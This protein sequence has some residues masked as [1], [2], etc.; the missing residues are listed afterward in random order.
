M[1]V[2]KNCDH[3]CHHGNGGTCHCGCLNCEHDIKDALDKLEEIE[4]LFYETKVE[5]EAD[6]DL[7]SKTH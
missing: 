2:C 7:D 5:F 6:F 3:E 4:N 1:A